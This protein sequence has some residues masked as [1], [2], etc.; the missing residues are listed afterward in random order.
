[1][2]LAEA[3]QPLRMSTGGDGTE[4]EEIGF[5]FDFKYLGHWFQSDGDGMRNIE[6]WMAQAGSAFGRLNHIWRDKR[7][8]KRVKL[9]LYATF[10]ISILV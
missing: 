6:I 1:M 4:P 3:Q 9:K 8:S 2:A 5:V 10:V 7:L